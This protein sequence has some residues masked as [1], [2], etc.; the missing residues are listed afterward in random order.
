LSAA[1]V[2]PCILVA[3][4]L[5]CGPTG[6]LTASLA[7]WSVTVC[8][9][10]VLLFRQSSG[11]LTFR[12][13]VFLTTWRYSTK[14]YI[15]TLA[16]FLVLRMNVFILNSLGG[17]EQVGYYS[18]AS[19]MADTM[20]ILPQSIATVLFPRLVASQ[21]DRLKTTMRD[22]ARTAGLLAI[23]CAAV[24]MLAEPIIQLAFG[25]QFAPAASILHALLPGVFFLGVMSVV[26]QYLAASGFPK[27]VV[28]C[29]IGAMALSAVLSH[30]LIG[31]HGA[32]G[33]AAA[34]SITYAALLM[35]L[36]Y[37]CW[38]TSRTSQGLCP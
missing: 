14:V 28:G 6:F 25:N 3:A 38:R 21:A 11:A 30:S 1:I 5:G 13:D 33:A 37:L 15:A 31:R 23:A 8:V 32:V 9:M 18:V 27:S 29:W 20:A 35:G 36:L 17:A 12:S 2:L 22:A 16:G 10:L 24:W 7:A 4:L 19:Q 26:S 34:L